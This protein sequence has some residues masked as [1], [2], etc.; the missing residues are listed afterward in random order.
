MIALSTSVLPASLTGA[1]PP[2]AGVLPA[3]PVPLTAQAIG[4]ATAPPKTEF[5]ETLAGLTVAASPDAMAWCEVVVGKAAKPG[6]AGAAPPLELPTT[7]APIP[8]TESSPGGSAPVTDLPSPA[9]KGQDVAADGKDLPADPGDDAASDTVIWLPSALVP[10]DLPVVRTKSPPKFDPAPAPVDAAPPSAKAMAEAAPVPVTAPPKSASTKDGTVAPDILVVDTGGSDQ[11]VQTI[12][13]GP[14]ILVDNGNAPR[15]ATTAK[16]AAPD[17]LVAGAIK[18]PPA[19]VPAGGQVAPQARDMAKPAAGRVAGPAQPVTVAPDALTAP[20]TARRAQASPVLSK[21]GGQTVTA[22]NASAMRQTTKTAMPPATPEDAAAPEVRVGTPAQPI[23]VAPTIP[24]PDGALTDVASVPPVATAPVKAAPIKTP[25][26]SPA[27]APQQPVR[28]NQLQVGPD[29]LVID[30]PVTA[31]P[32]RVATIPAAPD[33]L[34]VGE[35]AP[36]PPIKF[37]PLIEPTVQPSA[38]PT[39]Q[40]I[41]QSTAQPPVLPPVADDGAIP[42]SPVQAPTEAAPAVPTTGKVDLPVRAATATTM[43][44][45]AAQP[46]APAPAAPI[47]LPAGQVFAAAIAAVVQQA[48]RDEREPGDLRAP[49]MI[50]ATTFDA[51]HANAVAATADVRQA[52]LDLKQDSGLQGMIDHIELLRD[53]ADANDTRIRLVPDALGAVDVSVRRDG[54]RVHVHFAAENRASAQLLSDAQPRLA[55]LA[56]ARGLKLGQTSVDTGADPNR[57][58]TRQ[59]RADPAQPIR[60]AAAT[61]AAG[62]TASESRIA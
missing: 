35:T 9:K 54:D 11:P 12:P 2:P 27:A 55:D 43:T 40:P 28:I 19:D 23:K 26:G 29:I 60:P 3:T 53:G 46:Q 30:P 61:R 22:L 51:L 49:A 1:I 16:P 14:D 42:A 44:L 31:A 13:F 36:T 48:R 21:S 52:A 47:A 32:I 20:N 10:I 50:G 7:A 59:Q 41:A 39:V 4:P 37:A 58:Q 38:Q 33:I 18:T 57:G 8:P 25:D 5:S 62:P 45:P 6:K 56:E 24:A 34:V 17:I 15:P